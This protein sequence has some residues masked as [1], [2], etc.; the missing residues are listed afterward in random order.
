[1]NEILSVLI[2]FIILIIYGYL[3][4]KIIENMEGK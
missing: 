4:G 1:M 3:F 2:S